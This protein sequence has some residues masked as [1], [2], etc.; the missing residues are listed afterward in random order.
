MSDLSSDERAWETESLPNF[1]EH[2]FHLKKKVEFKLDDGSTHV[3]IYQGWGIFGTG[4]G[5]DWMH[6]VVAWRPHE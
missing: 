5:R 1:N 4:K 2:G 6:G 3:D